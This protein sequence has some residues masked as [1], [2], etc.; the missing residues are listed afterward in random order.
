[1]KRN[2][3]WSLGAILYFLLHKGQKEVATGKADAF[4]RSWETDDTA[5]S[6]LSSDCLDLLRKLLSC[7]ATS[8]ST[9]LSHPRLSCAQIL[10]HP[11]MKG[12]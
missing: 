6:T 12:K 1:M 5:N 3:C 2:D 7:D 9:P 4:K 8:T 10:E 11:W